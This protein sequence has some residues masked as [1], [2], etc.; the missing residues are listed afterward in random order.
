M[1]QFKNGKLYSIKP[2]ADGKGGTKSGISTQMGVPDVRTLS[3][4]FVWY[5]RWRKENDFF[6][7]EGQ[8]LRASA[9]T[10]ALHAFSRYSITDATA[11]P[12][13][14]ILGHNG[15]AYGAGAANTIEDFT[16]NVTIATTSVAG[17]FAPAVFSNVKNR[18][19]VGIGGDHSFIYDGTTTYD[20]GVAD[21]PASTTPY[22]L[23]PA[24]LV[25]S[26]AFVTQGSVYITN[27]GGGAFSAGVKS[28]EVPTGGPLY[29][30]ASFINSFSAPGTATAAG[31]TNQ[32]TINAAWPAG[33]QYNGLAITIGVDVGTVVAYSTNGGVTTVTL[34]AN[35][36]AHAGA[37]YTITG[38]QLQLNGA[39]TA[40]TAWSMSVKLHSG[41]LAWTGAGPK[42]AYCWYDSITGHISNA[43]PIITVTETNQSFVNVK[44]A[45]DAPGGSWA[46]GSG[47]YKLGARFDTVWVF[48][49]QLNGGSVL[50][51][52]A[53]VARPTSGAAVLNY[54]DNNADSVLLING[55]LQAPL[56]TNN[57]PQLNQT[58]TGSALFIHGSSFA[59]GTLFKIQPYSMA[60][61]T[62]TFTDIAA[63]TWT[64]TILSNTSTTLTLTGNLPGGV[65]DG[66]YNFTATVTN[67]PV[68]L[69]HIAS[70]DGRM[71]GS[72][73]EDPSLLMYSGD[74]VQIPFGVPEE[75]W[76]STNRIRIP[77]QDGK[78]TGIK[79]VSNVLL[80]L[81]ARY[82]YYIAGSNENN[83]RLVRYSTTM[84]GANE[85]TVDEMPGE[86]ENDASAIAFIGNDKRVYVMAPGY[87]SKCI[88]EP[89]NDYMKTMFPN[90]T[91]PMPYGDARLKFASINGRKLIIVS[92]QT[93][94]LALLYDLQRGIWSRAQMT[95]PGFPGQNAP[96]SMATIYG[97]STSTYRP[98]DEI[99]AM[100]GGVYSW[101]RDDFTNFATTTAFLTTFPLDFGSKKLKQLDFL[102]IYVSDPAGI[103]PAVGWNASVTVDEK[104]Q[105]SLPPG[106]YQDEIFSE[107][108]HL[109]TPLDSATGRELITYRAFSGGVTADQA[110]A[111]HRA[112]FTINWPSTTAPLDL[113]R[114]DIGYTE[115]PDDGELPT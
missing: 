10:R 100:G 80:I 98:V 62:L 47:T 34:A 56:V 6:A 4:A 78:I 33:G 35:M 48:R 86:S 37:A 39:I 72:P 49:T 18:C 88:S 14:N 104:T 22:S 76:P 91:N 96:Q 102:R 51:P 7:L 9:T 61:W 74:L 26:S 29:T 16:R 75:C 32:V 25:A 70:F 21:P 103:Y 111:F 71:W 64:A 108:D 82:A 99:A 68:G 65:T 66:T 23:D 1:A 107:Q 113:Y 53:K 42:Y 93:A 84:Y 110:I 8:T 28:V 13:Q 44:L 5:G 40:N 31:G 59:G 57:R 38:T 85:Y 19:F 17:V 92:S 67:G 43:S 94:N 52:L 106:Y 83:Y 69:A 73:T 15:P 60:G 20:I 90:N 2:D 3:N 77:S 11:L 97:G 105:Y 115:L 30:V 50:Y 81:T 24:T 101:L 46:P 89:V 12:Q 27:V 45:I 54:T 95:F 63:A 41:V 109:S 114:I 36:P 58:F 55:T 79:V 112:Q 87:G